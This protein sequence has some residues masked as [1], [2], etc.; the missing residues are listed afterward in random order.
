MKILIPVKGSRRLE[1]NSIQE[2]GKH[3]ATLANAYRRVTDNPEATSRADSYDIVSWQLQNA[4][5]EE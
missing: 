2:L 5:V 3:Y 1:F 4:Y